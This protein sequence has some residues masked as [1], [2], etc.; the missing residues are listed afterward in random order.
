MVYVC[1]PLGL[2]GIV[3]GVYGDHHGW[4][5][6]Q[7]F[8]TNLISS[9]TSVMF[10]IPTALLVLG[11]L[12]NAQAE[13]LQ[14]Q[15]I[16]R[17]AR[18]D[19]EA[20][21]QVLLR[22]FSAA[23][24]RSLRAQKTDLDRALTALR[25]VRPVSFAPG[26]GSYDTGQAVDTWLD[27]VRPLEAA[28]QQVLTG[29]TSQAVGLRALWLDDL[30]AH[31]EEL[32]QGLRFQ[33]AEA[34]QAWL[35]PTRTAEMRRLWVGLRDGNITRPLDLDPDSWRARERAVREPPTA[36]FQRG[37][38]RAQRVLAARKTWL[39]AFGVLLDGADELV[40]LP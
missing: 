31:W 5:E 39:D 11:Y 2:L 38:D 29:M 4:W 21:Q 33:M 25:R 12:S 17:R 36:A 1:V 26:Q 19:I 27:Q 30:Q 24:L 20:F 23:D 3:A 14:K 35:T 13:A 16:R 18:R 7:S 15:Q 8:L 40:A 6:H 9:L 28:Y 32:D 37:H 10:G 34:D 22:P